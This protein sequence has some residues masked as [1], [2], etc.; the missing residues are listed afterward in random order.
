MNITDFRT[1]VTHELDGFKKTMLDKDI[2]DIYYAY[3]Q[4]YFYESTSALITSDYFLLAREDE[5]K[6][7]IDILD[8]LPFPLAFLYDVFCNCEMELTSDWGATT[9]TYV[10]MINDGF[11]QE[12]AHEYTE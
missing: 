2:R 9:D 10:E 3:E 12:I 5:V 7:L 1:K 4:I 8:S 6:E 11:I